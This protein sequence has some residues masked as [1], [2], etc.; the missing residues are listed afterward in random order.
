MTVFDVTLVVCYC[1]FGCRVVI[2]LI[3]F[4]LRVVVV[5]YRFGGLG[6]GCWMVWFVF[7]LLFLIVVVVC[8]GV[9][10]AWLGVWCGLLLVLA[11]VGA[12]LFIALIISWV[13]CCYGCLVGWFFLCELVV[14]DCVLV[15]IV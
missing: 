7:C 9:I 2:R 6:C 14:C 11:C 3:V 5:C 12:G 1:L 10:V 4:T 13:I 15:V 8:F